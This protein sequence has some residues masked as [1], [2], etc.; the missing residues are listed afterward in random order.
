MFDPD[1]RPTDADA[2]LELLGGS[3]R[4]QDCKPIAEEGLCGP[5]RLRLDRTRLGD[6][7]RIRIEARRREEAQRLFRSWCPAFSLPYIDLATLGPADRRET[8]FEGIAELLRMLDFYPSSV[9][10]PAIAPAGGSLDRR[11]LRPI[12]SFH[13][14]CRCGGDSF[15][16]RPG[17]RSSGIFHMTSTMAFH[18]LSCVDC[19]GTAERRTA[20]GHE[21]GCCW[22]RMFWK[23]RCRSLPYSYRSPAS[24]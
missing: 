12:Q 19:S 18:G 22:C 10:T 23:I 16:R 9:G 17:Y 15:Y 6:R 5:L 20:H 21:A 1:D 2:A 4:L 13:G 11:P 24:A 14:G 7:R 3:R 8:W